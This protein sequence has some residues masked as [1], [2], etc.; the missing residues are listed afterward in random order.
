MT[1][2]DRKALLNDQGQRGYTRSGG[3]MA[4]PGAV[5]L[6]GH[7]LCQLG[8]PIHRHVGGVFC[9]LEVPRRVR[10]VETLLARLVAM[11]SEQVRKSRFVVGISWRARS[12]DRKPGVTVQTREPKVLA[13]L[14]KQEI[15]K[16]RYLRSAPLLSV[17]NVLVGL[18]RY[19]HF[20]KRLSAF[21]LQNTLFAEFSLRK[22]LLRAIVKPA[23]CRLGWQR[24]LVAA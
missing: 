7:L 16:H 20:I 13:V 10:D 4:P 3:R 21:S 18:T 6:R 14:V 24:G 19:T 8:V 22:P 5:R 15:A 2:R 1:A 9:D 17:V 23:W 11:H 12:R